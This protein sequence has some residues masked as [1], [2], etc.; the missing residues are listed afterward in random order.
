MAKAKTRRW[1][2]PTCGAGK[3]APSRPRRDDVRRF[4]LPCSEKSGRLVERICP[5]NEKVRERSVESSKRKASRVR[6][7]AR[8]HRETATEAART[9]KKTA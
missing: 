2:C 7:T 1:V 4:C 8:K 5:V 9:M 6:L 3:H